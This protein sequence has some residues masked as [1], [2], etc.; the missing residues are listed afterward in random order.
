MKT[1]LNTRPGWPQLLAWLMLFAGL[2]LSA[3]AYFHFLVRAS[4]DA[5]AAFEEESREAQRAIETRLRTYS[6]L[7]LGLRALHGSAGDFSAGALNDY[8]GTLELPERF[9]AVWRMDYQKVP[10]GGNAP[11]LFVYPGPYGTASPSQGHEL[12]P[13]RLAPGLLAQARDSNDFVLSRPAVPGGD[14]T[15]VQLRLAVQDR[16]LGIDTVKQRRLDF[17]GTVGMSIAMKK[18]VKEAVSAQTLANMHIRI[19]SLA[20]SLQAAP[21]AKADDTNLLVDT[22]GMV[23]SSRKAVSFPGLEEKPLSRAA[24]FA[25]GRALLE[26]EFSAEPDSFH[27]PMSQVWPAFVL[28]AGLVISLLLFGF[29]NS[30]ALS[31]RAL[32]FAVAERT[33]DLEAIRQALQ[34]EVAGRDQLEQEILHLNVDERRWF[35]QHLQ[36]NI[37]QRL[38]A[39]GFMLE[40]LAAEL[41]P[42]WPDAHAL[43]SRI[44]AHISSAIAHTRML[45][46]GLN[47]VAVEA[48]G[49][50]NGLARLADS[51]RETF[52]I[53]CHLQ[54]DGCAVPENAVLQHNLYR[55]AQQAI[56]NAVTH[57]KATH[58]V[59]EVS[60][61]GQG[62]RL[63]VV[64]DGIGLGKATS[65]SAS[66]LGLEIMCYRC[67]VL[68]L[69]LDI[70]A[71]PDGGTAIVIEQRH[72]KA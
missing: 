70:Q 8:V 14:D 44:E 16:H 37:A 47:P 24:Q 64:D 10:R 40:S 26:F 43:A 51:T 50:I 23:E 63:A 62:L 21:L 57:G 32:E 59:L 55:I 4:E 52:R 17:S 72:S 3:A 60:D 69:N 6:S 56:T 13:V 27:S 39:V 9:P 58:I 33:R 5:R 66:G 25:L 36:D 48:G 18:L 49:F 41:K 53:D 22:S 31:R 1:R 15:S 35:G 61:D 11:D 28:L 54:H 71:I 19:H 46:R 65:S 68:G 34:E 29:L 12:D 45:A 2:G 7:L 20:P 42:Q 67:N 38:T 30:L